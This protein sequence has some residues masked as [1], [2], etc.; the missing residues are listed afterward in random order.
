[1]GHASTLMRI[2]SAVEQAGIH[3]LENV[4]GGGIAVRLS[5]QKK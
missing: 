1:M 3:F 5:E 2:Q 4:S